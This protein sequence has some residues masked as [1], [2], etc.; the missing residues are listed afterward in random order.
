MNT[1]CGTTPCPKC[2]VPCPCDD[3]NEIDIG[4]GYQTWGHQWLCREHGRFAYPDGVDPGPAIFEDDALE[5]FL[6]GD[7]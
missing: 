5:G 1:A 3:H 4:V 2:A 7:S 6:D